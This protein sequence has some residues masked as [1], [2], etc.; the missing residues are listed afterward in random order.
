MPV[1][2]SQSTRGR[3]TR[4]Q[5]LGVGASPLAEGSECSAGSSTGWLMK[6]RAALMAA[7]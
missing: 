2:S 7:A 1:E 4:R 3:G 5:G 6:R